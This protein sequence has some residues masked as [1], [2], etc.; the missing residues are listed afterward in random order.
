VASPQRSHW[1]AYSAPPDPLAVFRGP[2]SK[3]KGRREEER[4]GEGR[5]SSFAPGRKKEKSAPMI[6]ITASAKLFAIQLMR[7]PV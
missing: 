6:N 5:S 2:T 7:Q 4:G 1:G 3:G